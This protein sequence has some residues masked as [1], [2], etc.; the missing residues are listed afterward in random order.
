MRKFDI[1]RSTFV[2]GAMTF[3]LVPVA[4]R[5]DGAKRAFRCKARLDSVRDKKTV[6]QAEV[7][8]PDGKS[9]DFL[10]GVWNYDRMPRTPRGLYAVFSVKDAAKIHLKADFEYGRSGREAAGA[11]NVGVLTD[12][13]ITV[14][15]DF[16]PGVAVAYPWTIAGEDYM[17]VVS[18]EPV[19]PK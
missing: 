18:V 6:R 9:V 8:V 3:V 13:K 14:E 10:D 16:E 15:D 4:A 7:V 11:N 19:T 2:A 17:I 1:D 5:A 12:S